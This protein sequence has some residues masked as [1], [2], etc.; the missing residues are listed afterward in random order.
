MNY[1]A[2]ELLITYAKKGKLDQIEYLVEEQMVNVNYEAENGFNVL[3]VAAFGGHTEIVEYLAKMGADI[4]KESRINRFTPL[5]CAVSRAHLNTAKKLVE[6]GAKTDFTVDGWLE[7]RDLLTLAIE[8]YSLEMYLYI[9]ED[10][11]QI[12]MNGDLLDDP[13]PARALRRAA[14]FGDR[15]GIECLTIDFRADINSTGP[16]GSNPIIL[17]ALNGHHVELLIDEGADYNVKYKGKSLMDIA[18][19]T[20]HLPN[21]DILAEHHVAVTR[22]V[23][24]KQYAKSVDIRIPAREGL[25]H[26]LEWLANYGA[27]LDEGI[28]ENETLLS[29]AINQSNLKLVRLLI[30]KGARTD[31]MIGGK[32]LLDLAKQKFGQPMVEFLSRETN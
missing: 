7:P 2:G 8:A 16:D 19:A 24:A 15:H 32:N 11:L 27:N 22:K 21:I 18:V 3:C 10:V 23:A 4:N 30:S 9:S 6:M 13:R 31:Q 20:R 17:A 14:S 26:A 5:A 29:K 1:Y 25:Y 12:G 28:E